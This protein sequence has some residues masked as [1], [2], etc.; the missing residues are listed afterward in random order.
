MGALFFSPLQFLHPSHLQRSEHITPCWKHSQY[1]FWHPDL[2]QLHPLKCLFGSFFSFSSAVFLGAFL[3]SLM[4]CNTILLYWMVSNSETEAS[5]V[6]FSNLLLKANGFLISICS[7][8][9]CRLSSWCFELLQ[10]EHLQCPLQYLLFLKHS[11][12]NF[13]HPELVQLQDFGP[14]S[15]WFSDWAGSIVEKGLLS[16]SSTGASIV[17]SICLARAAFYKVLWCLLLVV[18]LKLLACELL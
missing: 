4:S 17:L 9:W 5:L 6:L 2:L 10:Q 18:P 12:Y 15:F 3:F 7:M 16:T 8:A 13:K 11:Q 1:F 14:S